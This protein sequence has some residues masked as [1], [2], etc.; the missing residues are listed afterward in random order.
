MAIDPKHMKLAGDFLDAAADDLGRRGCNDW[1]WP[2]NW[3]VKE[4]AQFAFNYHIWNGD[5]EE[6]RFGMSMPDFAVAAYLAYL[7]RLESEQ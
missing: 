5:P 7:L 3:T 6:Y 1:S 2:D 4:R